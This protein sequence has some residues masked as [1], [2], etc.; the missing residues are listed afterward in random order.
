MKRL[1][2]VLLTVGLLAPA[3]PVGASHD[4]DYKFYVAGGS[5]DEALVH[6]VFNEAWVTVGS[7][8]Q[9]L[10]GADNVTAEFND[11][12]NPDVKVY[13]SFHEDEPRASVFGGPHEALETGIFCSEDRL[14]VPEGAET[15][16]FSLNAPATLDD[17]E[18]CKAGIATAGEYEIEL[19]YDD[20]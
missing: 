13:Y 1:V 12:A 8:V 9:D 7:I 16:R 2:I 10:D 15:I 5:G 11:L 20:D 3:I 6:I 17:T 4:P 14:K 18:N 19:L